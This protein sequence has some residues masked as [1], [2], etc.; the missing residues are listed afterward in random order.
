M[1][2]EVKPLGIIESFETFSETHDKKIRK[3][4]FSHRQSN[5]KACVRR[6]C[7]A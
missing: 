6:D 1:P 2:Q 7:Y 3:K 4:K 5:V